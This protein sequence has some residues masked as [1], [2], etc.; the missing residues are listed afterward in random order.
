MKIGLYNVITENLTVDY[1]Y[2]NIDQFEIYYK[3]LNIYPNTKDFF[4]SPFV[5]DSTPSLRFRVDTSYR[6]IYKCFATNKTG[7]VINLVQELFNLN[8]K[9]SL[10]KIA[11]D[12]NLF[13]TNNSIKKENNVY[14]KVK[15]PNLCITKK[16]T[17]QVVIYDDPPISF[18]NYWKDFYINKDLLDLYDVKAVE[19]VYVEKN[20]QL[21]KSVYK[22]SDI[23]IRYLV[24]GLY[25]IYKPL[26]KDKKFKWLS[27]FNSKCIFGFKQLKYDSDI[28]ILSKSAKDVLVWRLLSF[29]AI[30]LHNESA[31]LWKEFVDYFKSKYTYIIVVLDNDRAGI[32]SMLKYKKEWNLDFIILPDLGVEYQCKDL[33]E[34]IYSIGYV[35][36]K[37]LVNKLITNKI[38][39]IRF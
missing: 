31:N 4:H 7:D 29:E 28:L 24:N 34:I 22:D 23:I 35:E 17:I 6:L 1:L 19:E 39:D 10:K 5:E 12:F 16:S 18:I 27:T 9:E 25:K 21:Y 36:T 8:L 30:T 13:R 11:Y 38:N 26:S 33:A 2:N 15:N 20:D 32:N 3:Y 37:V 14:G